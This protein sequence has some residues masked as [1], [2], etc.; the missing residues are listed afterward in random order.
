M[1]KPL[2]AKWPPLFRTWG[3]RKHKLDTW[4]P[5]MTMSILIKRIHLHSSH[6]HSDFL[7]QLTT[8]FTATTDRLQMALEAACL[9]MLDSIFGA[10]PGTWVKLVSKNQAAATPEFVFLSSFSM[11]AGK[12]GLGGGPRAAFC[13]QPNRIPRE[14]RH[15]L[16]HSRGVDTLKSWLGVTRARRPKIQPCLRSA[17]PQP[18]VSVSL[19]VVER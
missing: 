5:G 12:R 18:P 9:S 11:Q 4:D 19:S 2:L 8:H 17:G 1:C 10:Q 16:Q 13:G 14:I 7:L 6:V 15:R 3:E